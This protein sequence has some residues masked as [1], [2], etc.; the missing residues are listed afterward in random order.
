M[1]GSPFLWLLAFGDAKESDCPARHE[2]A[3]GTRLRS[4][5]DPPHPNPLPQGE[6]GL[7]CVHG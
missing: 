7:R 6:R 4:F 3:R 1:S 5:D 2:R